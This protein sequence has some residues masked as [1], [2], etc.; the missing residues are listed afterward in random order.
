MYNEKDDLIVAQMLY[1]WMQCADVF[2]LKEV[3]D[4]EF[5]GDGGLFSSDV[6]NRAKALRHVRE[7]KLS[8]ESREKCD[9]LLRRIEEVLRAI[10]YAE[11]SKEW[12]NGRFGRV[13]QHVRPV[14]I[15]I[16]VQH[17]QK[18]STPK[19]VHM[20][21]DE[22]ILHVEG[23]AT[24]QRVIRHIGKQSWPGKP[25]ECCSTHLIDGDGTF[26]ATGLDSFIKGSSEYAYLAA[27]SVLQVAFSLLISYATE[28]SGAT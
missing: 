17:L 1:P 9:V 20:V 5:D 24:S 22:F 3:I 23:T 19:N 21:D 8:L 28:T 16:C 2:F 12:I 7:L 27:G 13:G 15:I 18:Q 11:E 6:Q 25:V 10:A 14:A 26:N 4:V